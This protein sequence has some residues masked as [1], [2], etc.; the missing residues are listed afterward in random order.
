MELS[1]SSFFFQAESENFFD[2]AEALIPAE[3]F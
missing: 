2:W 1:P 3:N